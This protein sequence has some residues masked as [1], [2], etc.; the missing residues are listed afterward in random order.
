MTSGPTNTSVSSIYW[1]HLCACQDYNPSHRE[2]CLPERAKG[3][4]SHKGRIASQKLHAFRK[5]FAQAIS[6]FS[7][8]PT[9]PSFLPDNFQNVLSELKS[10]TEY[11]LRELC[12]AYIFEDNPEDP[13]PLLNELEFGWLNKWLSQNSRLPWSKLAT[14]KQR[15][16]LRLQRKRVINIIS[17]SFDHC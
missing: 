1:M 16:C 10:S 9:S 3:V 2:Q 8:D 7:S 11:N 15:N 13:D 6:K 4:N 17:R 5:P 12:K 14:T